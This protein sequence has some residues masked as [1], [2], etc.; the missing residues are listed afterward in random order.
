MNRPAKACELASG[1][2]TTPAELCRDRPEL[3]AEL[4]KK[5]DTL[6]SE[7]S[8]AVG[9]LGPALQR[10]VDSTTAI[11][12][13]FRDNLFGRL[14]KR[15]PLAGD[16]PDVL[17]SPATGLHL[18][19][20]GDGAAKDAVGQLRRDLAAPFLALGLGAD[21]AALGVSDRNCAHSLFVS[22]ARRSISAPFIQRVITHSSLD[23]LLVR[24][25]RRAGLPARS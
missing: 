14:L 6:L 5:I 10:L 12:S 24:R 16:L 1:E 21:R 13:D 20:D 11:A 3:Q 23:G 25:R 7:A 19:L 9:G 18:Y 8:Q 22:I 17:G 15:A 4:E 2:D